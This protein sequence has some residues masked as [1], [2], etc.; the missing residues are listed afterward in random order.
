M[1]MMMHFTKQ[2]IYLPAN[3]ALLSLH[4]HN[5][6]NAGQ[7][8]TAN[9]GHNNLVSL[10]FYNINVLCQFMK[11]TVYRQYVRLV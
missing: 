10:S 6:P 9:K 11:R 3:T 2:Q 7:R 4:E 5:K 8:I 1:M